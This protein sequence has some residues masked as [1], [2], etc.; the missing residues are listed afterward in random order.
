MKKTKDV[1][2]F[3]LPWTKEKSFCRNEEGQCVCISVE[4]NVRRNGNVSGLQ[5]MREGRSALG[6]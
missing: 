1:W 4:V 5:G 3:G 6:S 2:I